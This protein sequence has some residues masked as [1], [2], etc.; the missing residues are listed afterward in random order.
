[1]G[2]PGGLGVHGLSR[3]GGFP[4]ADAPRS[5][6]GRRSLRASPR[7]RSPAGGRPVPLPSLRASH[8]LR[9]SPS[10]R[11][12]QGRLGPPG[13]LGVHGLPSPSLGAGRDDRG[14][15]A[16]ASG[17]CAGFAPAGGDGLRPPSVAPGPRSRVRE[18]AR[19]AREDLLS[20]RARGSVCVPPGRHSRPRSSLEGRGFF[21]A[22]CAC[23]GESHS[24]PRA[25]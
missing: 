13:G 11:G 22:H 12:V 21:P 17:R 25:K 15:V 18:P 2:P 7:G 5:P 14:S 23:S 6:S 20:N 24:F 9:W 16:G 4:D 1:M 10:G 19:G 3:H 8:G